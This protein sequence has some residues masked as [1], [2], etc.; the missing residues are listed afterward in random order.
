MPPHAKAVTTPM[1]GNSQRQLA[2]KAGSIYATI[3]WSPA[4][5][6]WIAA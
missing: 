5:A 2:S 1:T 3:L 6:C 4:S